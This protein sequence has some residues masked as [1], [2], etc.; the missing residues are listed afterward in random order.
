MKPVFYDVQKKISILLALLFL[1]QSC[2]V[3]HSGTADIEEAVAAENKVK[4]IAEDGTKYKFK[5]LKYEEDRLLGVTRLNSSTAEKVAGM[6]TEIEGK[7]LLVDL[8]EMP[9]RKIKIRNNTLSTVINIGIPVIIAGVA[10]M[11][12]VVDALEDS[13]L[14]KG[15][16][17]PIM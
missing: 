5:K 15:T 4:I 16:V 17:D 6:S 2:S 1:F 13:E 14:A 10:F 8:S 9:I 12:Y 3:Y 7:N 11:F